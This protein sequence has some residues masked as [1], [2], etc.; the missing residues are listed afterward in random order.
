M[1]TANLIKLRMT[2]AYLSTFTTGTITS[3]LSGAI[4]WLNVSDNALKV[5]VYGNFGVTSTTA[6]VTFPSTGTWYSYLNDSV[7]TINSTSVSVTLPPGAYYVFTSKDIVLPINLLSFT[8]E[9]S[10]KQSVQL[11]GVPQTRSTINT[12]KFSAAATE[13]ILQRLVN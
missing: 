4:K 12:S 1:F 6:T 2:P 10:G 7:A 3:N 13:P 5:V 8:A 9:K 11:N